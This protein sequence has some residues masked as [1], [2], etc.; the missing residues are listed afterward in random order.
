MIDGTLRDDLEAIIEG[1]GYRMV[2]LKSQP[3]RD[4]LV[5]SLVVHKSG[6]IGLEDCEVVHRTILPRL[7]AVL[8]RDDIRMEVSSPGIGRKLK[9]WREF[10]AFKGEA[11]SLGLTDG[12]TMNGVLTDRST[13]GI[14]L[15][16]D[17][18]DHAID[19]ES[20]VWARLNDG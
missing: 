8:E 3:I 19:E 13:G 4:T 6:G 12:T 17:G 2:E 9:S 18:G 1:L 11:F 15:T 16:N 7:E 5:V 10:N 14:T 20:I